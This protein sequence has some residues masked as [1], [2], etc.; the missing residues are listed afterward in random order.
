MSDI[1]IFQTQTLP[2]IAKL[3]KLAE[4]DDAAIKEAITQWKAN[5]PLK[6]YTNLLE[7]ET[8]KDAIPEFIFD[9]KLQRYR[10]RDTGRFLSQE[11]MRNLSQKAIAQTQNDVGTISDLLVQG[12][13]FLPTWEN[14]TAQALKVLHS[15]QTLLGKGGEKQ[16]NQRDYG[17]LGNKLKGEYQYLRGFA[18]DLANGKMSEAQFRW[19]SNLYIQSARGSY[20]RS[21][22]EAHTEA[23]YQ[24]E[25]RI[26]LAMESCG[27][28]LDWAAKGWQPIGTLPN[29]TENCECIV[30]CK[31]IKE[32]A[33]E[34][35]AD[36]LLRNNFGWL[37][38]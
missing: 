10:Y 6:I 28:C 30:N 7:A 19:R 11:A 18:E 25:R 5:P 15:Q 20:E 16:I 23:G 8:A 35:P 12:K 27:S 38:R 14:A 13:I 22:A 9:K 4:I 36:F 3:L 31:C 21:K 24:W 33:R 26:R 32:F 29:P 34:K 1:L 37:T 2:P 17:L